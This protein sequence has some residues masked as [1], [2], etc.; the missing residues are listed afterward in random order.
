MTM[1]SGGG[2]GI[3]ELLARLHRALQADASWHATIERDGERVTVTRELRDR[4]RFDAG[5][6]G[7]GLPR[8]TAALEQ[9]SDTVHEAD[10]Q[11]EL[12]GDGDDHQRFRKSEGH[13]ATSRVD[14][15]RRPSQTLTS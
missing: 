9:S 14:T 12:G 4:G 8:I 2:P 7:R 5:G 15:V 11:G 6:S 3:T 13:G 10:H 1:G